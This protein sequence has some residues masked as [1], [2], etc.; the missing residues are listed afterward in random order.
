M[1]VDLKRDYESKYVEIREASKRLQEQSEHQINLEKFVS[2]FRRSRKTFFVFR[3]KSQALEEEI[4]RLKRSV[5]E[6]EKRYRD[7]EHEFF[8]FKEKQKTTPEVKLQAELNLLT[9]EKV[10]ENILTEDAENGWKKYDFLLFSRTNY[11]GKWRAPWRQLNVINNN[12]S[13]L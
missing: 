7:K 13:R 12:G 3:T 8:N 11:N 1:N 10:C 4:G 6:W 5:N 9:L 2:S